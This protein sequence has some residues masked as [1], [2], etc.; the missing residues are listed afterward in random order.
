MPDDPTKL[1]IRQYNALF[2]NQPAT[3][4]VQPQAAGD[5]ITSVDGVSWS[6]GSVT[7]PVLGPI[8]EGLQSM[9]TGTGL[10]VQDGAASFT[11]REITSNDGT[12]TI[13]NADGVAGNIDLSIIPVSITL[14]V[15]VAKVASNWL[16]SY[17]DSTGLFTQSQPAYTDLTGTPQL[18]ITQ[19]VVASNWLNSYDSV[20]GLFTKSQPAYSDLTGTPTLPVTIAKVAS[21]WV[22]SYTSG[23]GAF[24]STQ[25]A[26][27]DIS[28]TP[29]L[30][31]TITSAASKWV[32][33]YD[34]VTGLF[35]QTQ[36]AYSEI[37]GTPQLA[38]TMA[39]A[40]NKWL[41]SYDAVTGLFTQTQPAYTEISGTPTL[42][43]TIAKVASKWVD[44]YTSGTGAFTSTQPAYT[45]ISG[46]PTLPVTIAVA[47][48][49]FLTSYTSTTGAFTAAQ[50]AF[51]DISGTATIAQG[52]TNN[53][54]LV[55]TAGVLPRGD[56][57]KLVG[58]ALGT[59]NQILQVNSGATDIEWTTASALT[60]PMTKTGDIIY[61]SD[62]SGTP[63]RLAIGTNAKLMQPA[64]GIPAYSAFTFPTA[65][66]ANKIPIGDGTNFVLTTPTYPNSAAT[67]GAYIRAD[68]TNF[69]QSTLILPNAAATGSVPYATSTDT[70]GVLAPTANK[71]IGFD[72]AGTAIE[73][74]S[75]NAFIFDPTT[76][77]RH[78]KQWVFANAVATNY[79]NI[80]QAS[81][82]TV[83]GTGGASSS[84]NSTGQ[85]LFCTGTAVINQDVGVIPTIFTFV[86]YQAGP[87]FYCRFKTGAV[88]TN[89]RFYC[90]L[91]ESD[92]V[93][94]TADPTT[95]D[96][97]VF[98]YDTGLDTVGQI[99]TLSCDGASG[100][101]KN[102]IS[103][104][105]YAVSSTYDVVIDGSTS[106]HIYFWMRKDGGVFTRVAD[107]STRFPGA[108]VNL[109]WEVKLRQLTAAAKDLL[110]GPVMLTHN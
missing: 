1:G 28:G 59:K 54:S 75:P 97:A 13:T 14:P 50:P 35:T 29:Q 2:G 64:S 73:A 24:T 79:T 56:G 82:I 61:S 45:D 104:I 105:A 87:I 110:T 11:K 65:A 101:E 88:I 17:D 30:P 68:G 106:G 53:G 47:S 41:K 84:F 109:G 60:N 46:T 70:I 98:R 32:K 62:N 94:L 83:G 33:S 72:N 57:T 91:V 4:F 7:I 86:Q 20:T 27:S 93:T 23:T 43:V 34:S 55:V 22:D 39:S 81:T 63:A 8:L 80:G 26:Y 3:N 89:S 5:V 74:K 25:P 49:K 85:Y 10:V 21:K 108:A 69:I 96:C 16:D 95:Q 48:T 19:G 58:L 44:S 77:L 76:P 92:L 67:T 107:H 9:G 66:T 18:P 100:V 15:T 12:V 99:T 102:S 103:S 31:I 42:P 78:L 51:T 52:G 37:S 6:S 90:G 71:P 40:A 36:P 38:Q